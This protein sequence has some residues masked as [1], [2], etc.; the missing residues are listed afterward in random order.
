ME[1]FMISFMFH[2]FFAVCFCF[3]FRFIQGF[4]FKKRYTFKFAATNDALLIC[5]LV[6]LQ[7]ILENFAEFIFKHLSSILII[8]SRLCCMCD[9]IP[10]AVSFKLIMILELTYIYICENRK[11][12]SMAPIRILHT[13][14]SDEYV[15]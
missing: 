5:S 7:R 13:V 11:Q 9:Y 12:D 6:C 2:F 14:K 1:K 15:F 4:I 8:I 10:L 3:K